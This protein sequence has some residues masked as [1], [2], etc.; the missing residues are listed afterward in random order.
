MILGLAAAGIGWHVKGLLDTHHLE[1]SAYRLTLQLRELQS[2]ALTYQSDMELEILQTEKGISYRSIIDEPLKDI[3]LKPHALDS[4]CKLTFNDK[5]VSSLKFK[6][7]A[8]GRIEPLG[9]LELRRRGA[10]S[11]ASIDLTK[12]LLIKLRIK[13]E[14][15]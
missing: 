15:Q 5:E 9:T 13:D 14:K 3:S 6:I 4:R 10:P 11:F 8:S 1:N 7:S 2:L 12:P